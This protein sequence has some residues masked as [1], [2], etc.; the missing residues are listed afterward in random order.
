MVH[1]NFMPGMKLSSLKAHKSLVPLFACIGVGFF[2]AMF[3]L[4]R[5]ATQGPD[6]CFDKKNSPHPNLK[7]D[8]TTQY[9]FYSPLRDYSKESFPPER[10]NLDE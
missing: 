3:Y 2:G 8:P 1:L 6:V 10:P 5:L 9:K 4:A 7:L